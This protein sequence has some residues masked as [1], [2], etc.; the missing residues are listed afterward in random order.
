MPRQ[1]K[2]QT[3]RLAR[4]LIIRLSEYEHRFSL[5]GDLREGYA[6]KCRMV[7]I[8]K[9]RLWY[10]SQVLKTALLY[11][12]YIIAGNVTMFTN[13]L[14]IT[15]RNFKKQKGYSFL[16]IFGLA[17]GM[18]CCILILL[19][20]QDELSF[21]NFHENGE[22]IYRVVRQVRAEN[23]DNVYVY[24]PNPLGPAIT[25]NLPEV[26]KSTRYSKVAWPVMAG[27]KL[28]SNID[29][30]LADTT[31]FDMFTFTVLQGNLENVLHD[32][33]SIVITEDMARKCFG[34]EDPLGQT[35]TGLG[36]DYAVAAVVKNIPRNSHIQ[37]ECVMPVKYWRTE[38]L[39]NWSYAWQYA[40]YIQF[41]ENG[42]NEAIAGQ[43]ANLIKENHPEGQRMNMDIMLQPFKHIHLRS[44]WDDKGMNVREGHITY[45]YLFSLTAFCILIIACVNFMSLATA[46]S[47]KRQKEIGMRKV[48][49]ARRHDVI[50]QFFG[51][52]IL[53]SIAALL[54][55]LILIALAMPAFNT[56]TGKLIRFNKLMEL[57]ALLA[58]SGITLCTGLIAGTYPAMFLS[59]FIPIKVLKGSDGSGQRRSSGFRSGLVV[60][61]FAF[62]ILLITAS[63]VIYNQ[64]NYIKNKDLG[65]DKDCI[66]GFHSGSLRNRNVDHYEPFRNELLTNPGIINVTKSV[67]PNRIGSAYGETDDF[68]FPGKNPDD[69]VKLFYCNADY[70]YLSTFGIGLAEGRYFSKV[71]AAD[72]SNYLLNEAAVKATGMEAPVGKSFTFQGRRGTIIGIIKD[73][74]IA[75]LHSEI[76][77]AVFLS[78]GGWNIYIKIS[79]EN[80]EE[81]L[82][83][84]RTV[85]EKHR[86]EGLFDLDYD[87]LDEAITNLYTSEVNMSKVF[88]LFTLLAIFIS[89]LG[90][91]GLASFMAE[92]RVKEIGIRKTL[93]APLSSIVF[94]LFR[95][96]LK[97]VML[98]N[99]IAMPIAYLLIR[100]W[101]HSFAFHTDIHPGIFVLTGLITL[102][103][104]LFSAGYQTIKAA[105]ANPVDSLKYE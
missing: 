91:I 42:Y 4:L 90:L 18:A 72:T 19:W 98:A 38:Y 78:T 74:H 9:A 59:S 35:I 57:N 48:V 12:Q 44:P 81:T 29:M 21:D 103:I 52:S 85:W 95:T 20:V 16:N 100:N 75:S 37:F 62:T 5:D 30:C 2:N 66:L 40:V 63:L 15:W 53:L 77:P 73:F 25:Q 45:V 69:G 99:L 61:Q 54:I 1:K 84:L 71:F 86:L 94:L 65:Y 26:K 87:F 13:Y 28:F 39:A 55:A 14:K 58:L 32:P 33:S 60:G 34:D 41:H 51:E 50:R 102:I 10:W 23:M 43:I 89:F 11:L 79:T 104:V 80:R 49:G 31:F 17:V 96:F 92:Q 67:A 6:Y 46:R 3:P 88:R 82:R 24:M 101:L 36:T 83:F 8:K 105:Y 22:N 68:S 7:G 70:D 97:W 76:K 27:D 64:L 56:F 93:G 47:G